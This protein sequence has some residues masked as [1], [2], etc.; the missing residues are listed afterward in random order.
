[1]KAAFYEGNK[2]IRLGECIPQAPKAGEVQLKVSH[3]GICGTDL[4]IYHGAM[5]KRVS[6][7]QI[8]GHEMSGT[9]AAVGEGVT[10]VKAGDPVTVMPLDTT[11]CDPQD[12][13]KHIGKNMKFMGIDT[14]GAFQ[15]YWT[16]PAFTLH[17]LPASLSLKHGAL[18]EPLAVACHDVRLADLQAG[19]EAVVLGGGPIGMLVALVA[20][21]TGAKVTLS[22][23]SPFRVEFAKSLGLDAVNPKEKDLQSYM[24]EKTS[25]RGAD[26][27]FEVTGSSAGAATMTTLPRIRG[28]LIVVGI[29]P[30]PHPVDLFQFFWKELIMKGAR[31]YEDEDFDSAIKLADSGK[32]PLDKIITETK[33]LEDAKAAF[34]R[35][36]KGADVMKIVLEL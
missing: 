15:D 16:V 5:D 25:G 4:H 28:R 31:V 11:R 2:T 36:E 19:E 14:P 9:V 7:P 21:A 24:Q 34:E 17:T 23:I 26:V 10:N 13:Y 35:M 12:P 22:E 30:T 8:M 32:L 1:M 33:P 27:V 6:F 18:L 20:R 29:A 3:V